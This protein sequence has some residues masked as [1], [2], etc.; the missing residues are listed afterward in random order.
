MGTKNNPSAF[1]CYANANP[2][3]PMFILLARDPAAPHALVYWIGLRNKLIEMGLKPREDVKMLSEAA[4]LAGEMTSWRH[5][6]RRPSG[7]QLMKEREFPGTEDELAILRR[8]LTRPYAKLQFDPNDPAPRLWTEDD[9]AL[10]DPDAIEALQQH[11]AGRGGDFEVARKTIDALYRWV[12][13]LDYR[14]SCVV[15][16]ATSILSKTNYAVSVYE[17][18]IDDHVNKLIDDAVEEDR[19][20]R[21]IPGLIEALKKAAETFR[22]YEAHHLSKPDAD[23]AKRNADMAELCEGAAATASRYGA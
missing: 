17:G 21:D 5:R 9:T 19:K 12:G 7:E 3:E 1:D 10:T 18:A 14:F 11:L 6:N 4:V 8:V 15:N 20:E 2:D 13:D 23:K 22:E 16:H